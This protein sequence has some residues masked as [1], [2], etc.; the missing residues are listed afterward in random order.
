MTNNQ[1]FIALI[2]V[3]V[4]LVTAA[5]TFGKHYLDAKIDPI[6]V[7]VDRLIDYLILHEGKIASLEERTKKL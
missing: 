5:A 4:T 7:Q 2:A 6:R 3:M 1:M